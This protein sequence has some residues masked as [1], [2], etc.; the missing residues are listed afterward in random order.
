MESIEINGKTIPL[1][2]ESFAGHNILDVTVGSTGWAKG[3]KW[4]CG[5]YLELRDGGCT[6]MRGFVESDE[7]GDTKAVRLYFEGE[8][9]LITLICALRFALDELTDKAKETIKG[10]NIDELYKS[11]T[12]PPVVDA[13]TDDGLP[14]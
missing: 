8:S 6:N 14:F 7:W 4:D 11:L 2:Q 10:F 12:Q 3:D 5:T 13:T 9:E 1:K